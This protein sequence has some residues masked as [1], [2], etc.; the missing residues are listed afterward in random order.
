VPCRLRFCAAGVSKFPDRRF[1]AP[2]WVLEECC[3]DSCLGKN[4]PASRERIEKVTA[5]EV[6]IRT[7]ATTRQDTSLARSDRPDLLRP[8]AL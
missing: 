7:Q 3:W 1:S 4:L 5:K 8:F 6:M 2:G